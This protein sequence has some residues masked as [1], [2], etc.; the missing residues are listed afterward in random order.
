[1]LSDGAGVFAGIRN[2]EAFRRANAFKI[3][4]HV[5]KRSVAFPAPFR[6]LSNGADCADPQPNVIVISG[7]IPRG[8]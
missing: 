4:S 5:S 7:A 8:A 3:V 1:M 6:M 2:A